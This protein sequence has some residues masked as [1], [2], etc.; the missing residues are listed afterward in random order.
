LGLLASRYRQ[1]GPVTWQ[2]V[3]VMYCYR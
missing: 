3:F 1:R 2:P